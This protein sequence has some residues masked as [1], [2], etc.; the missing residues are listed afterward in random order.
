MVP[1]VWLVYDATNGSRQVKGGYDPVP[2]C[3]AQIAASDDW[4]R[5]GFG[6]GMSYANPITESMLAPSWF[7]QVR[8][9]L[10]KRKA[11]VAVKAPELVY[12]AN[13]AP[14]YSH[15]SCDPLI[16]GSGHVDIGRS[17]FS[18]PRRFSV[19][20]WSCKSVSGARWPQDPSANI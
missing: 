9:S 11:G 2:G 19:H 7:P 5:A 20:Q 13:N 18:F 16:D 14:K 1:H 17:I 12:L 8:R 15:Y 4:L 3:Y 6:I 10:D